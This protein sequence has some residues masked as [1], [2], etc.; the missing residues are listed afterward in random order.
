MKLGKNLI[1]GLAGSIWTAV[2]ALAV[3]PLYIKYLGIEA[4][5]LIGFFSTMQALFQILD[6]GLSPTMNRE[7]ARH[8][9]AGNIRGSGQ[10]LHTLAVIYWAIAALIALSV[11][12]ASGFIAR[13]WLNPEQLAPE[14][15]LE[16]VI[17]MG[18]ISACRWP[19]TLYTGALMGAQRLIM[20][21]CIN[22]AMVTIGSAGALA[23]LAYISATIQAFFVWQLLVG[24]LYAVAMRWAAWKV[25]DGA[26]HTRFDFSALKRVWGF[27]AGMT[28]V[29][30]SALVFT[31]LDKVLLSPILGLDA[32]GEYALATVVANSL[33]LLSVPLFN[34]VYARLSALVATGNTKSLIA[35]YRLGTR[36]LAT[37][38]FPAA[39]LLAVF[40][41][42]IVGLWTGNTALAA[43]IAPLI[44]LLAMGSALNGVMC[45]P[46][47][48]QLAYGVTRLPLTI[49][50]IMVTIM[51]PTTCLLAIS[52]GALGGAMAWLLLHTMYLLLGTW[53]THRRLLA[54]IGIHWLL[55]DVGIP[56]GL[57]IIAGLIGRYAVQ[58][59]DFSVFTRL[60]YAVALALL[61]SLI[62]LAGS[63]RLRA[64]A[65]I[66]LG[67]RH[68]SRPNED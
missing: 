57:A 28:G 20:V 61:T 14:A 42:E 4:Y 11:F 12:I 13:H 60:A 6:F 51:I 25:I 62:S 36:A 17:L 65:L 53:L 18:L 32:F 22:V 50:G 5:G 39:M 29:A 30:I 59:A 58:K 34:A 38:L 47:A 8:S 41:E 7:V 52:Y 45:F 9:A 21:S 66:S 55:Q 23:V 64:A 46:Y 54:G 37:A 43:R 33:N 48:L 26:S 3:V 67:A 15:I 35:L 1:A 40:G 63:P 56:F 68:V 24:L 2:V 10:L 16:S 27:S 49:N 31:Q 19:V 44:A